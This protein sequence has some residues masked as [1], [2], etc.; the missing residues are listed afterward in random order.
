MGFQK[1]EFRVLGSGT[2]LKPV[3][4]KNMGLNVLPRPWSLG[5]GIAPE[6]RGHNAIARALGHELG[7]FRPRCCLSPFLL[8][9]YKLSEPGFFG[10]VISDL[11]GFLNSLN[12]G[13]Q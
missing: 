5:S 10:I 1:I 3:M 8:G 7:A 9:T 6:P 4:S 11:Q 13:L 2:Y 12:L